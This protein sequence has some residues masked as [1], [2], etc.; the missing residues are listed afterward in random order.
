MAR[1]G[2]GGFLRAIG[3]PD[4]FVD[5]FCVEINDWFARAVERSWNQ[6]AEAGGG[7]PR[8][9]VASDVWGILRGGAR[10]L[11]R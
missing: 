7:R 4:V 5:S 9:R 3:A 11:R 10:P 1:A 6:W 8:V 2:M